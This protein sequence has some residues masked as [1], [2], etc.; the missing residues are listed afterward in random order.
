MTDDQIVAIG[1]ANLTPRS[2]VSSKKI[3]LFVHLGST[4]L[5]LRELR[6]QF[7][8][9]IAL[10]EAVLKPI[11]P[12][13]LSKV[14]E[15]VEKYVWCRNTKLED[16]AQHFCPRILSCNTTEWWWWKTIST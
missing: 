7:E 11:K 5:L 14:I 12:G 1:S 3:T 15:L 9:D 8:K 2:M 16:C 13:P 4:S 6:K 10:S